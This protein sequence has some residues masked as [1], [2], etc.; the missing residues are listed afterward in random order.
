MVALQVN[1]AICLLWRPSL[2]AVA[3]ASFISQQVERHLLSVWSSLVA[4]HERSRNAELWCL[5]VVKGAPKEKLF[6]TSQSS[7]LH[8]AIFPPFF[9]VSTKL[10]SQ[11]DGAQEMALMVTWAAPLPAARALTNFDCVNV[12]IV[13]F[14]TQFQSFQI[15]LHEFLF[16]LS[17]YANYT[18]QLREHF[19]ILGRSL[20]SQ[21]SIVFWMSR[22]T[23]WP[24]TLNW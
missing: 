10:T 7:T 8:G 6:G 1:F 13:T 24:I 22:D 3:P 18:I 14:R 2:T 5:P 15:I 4:S 21:S 17:E 19:N 9:R 20:A 11:A 12:K 23:D 16:Q